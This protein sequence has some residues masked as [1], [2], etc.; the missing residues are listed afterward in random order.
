MRTLI[1]AGLLVIYILFSMSKYSFG[2]MYACQQ[3]D[4]QKI[5]APNPLTGFPSCPFGTFSFCTSPSSSFGDKTLTETLCFCLGFGLGKF[6]GIYGG[7][8]ITPFSYAQWTNINMMADCPND[9]TISMPY[10]WVNMCNN[11]GSFGGVYYI[12]N[13]ECNPNPF[14][15]TCSC[16]IT[17]PLIAQYRLTVFLGPGSTSSDSHIIVCYMS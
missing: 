2:G 9:S 4:T 17:A 13:G 7:N 11:I 5:C 16:P 8:V 10:Y 3:F 12:T 6:G 14:T 15:G 1:V